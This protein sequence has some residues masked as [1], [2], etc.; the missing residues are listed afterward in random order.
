MEE[1]Y[2]NNRVTKD[3]YL[4]KTLTQGGLGLGSVLVSNSNGEIELTLFYF[5]VKV[6]FGLLHLQMGNCIILYHTCTST[7][8]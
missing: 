7:Y 2:R 1:T 8:N 5:N 4:Y 3:I 6:N